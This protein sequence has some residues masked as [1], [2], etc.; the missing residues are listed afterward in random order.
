MA[1]LSAVL[2]F[3]F[4][5]FIAQFIGLRRQLLTVNGLRRAR[6]RVLLDFQRQNQLQIQLPIA[7]LRD[8]YKEEDDAWH[9]MDGDEL[10]GEGKISGLYHR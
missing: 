8:H 5:Y 2:S 7:L 4:A 1:L 6:F 10:D 3:A 9:A